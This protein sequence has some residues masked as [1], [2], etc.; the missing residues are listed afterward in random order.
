[1]EILG[2][3]VFREKVLSFKK[4]RTAKNPAIQTIVRI[5][6]GPVVLF[7]ISQQLG[8]GFF[9]QLLGINV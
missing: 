3:T 5:K 1:M 7:A 6:F 9:D 8:N 4:R 2:H